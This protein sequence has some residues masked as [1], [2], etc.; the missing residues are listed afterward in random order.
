[1]KR[2]L[3][4]AALAMALTPG[5]L[6]GHAAAADPAAVEITFEVDD[7]TGAVMVALFD[8]EA[9]YQK[10]LP[11]KAAR[12]PIGSG[13]VKATFAGLKPGRYAAK[14]FH[15]VD[16]DGGMNVNAF[17]MPTEQYGFSNKAQPRFGPAPWSAAA[18]EVGAGSTAQTIA[19]KRSDR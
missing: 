11:V 9:G 10:N 4:A 1:M 8:S 6:P 14:A 7:R 3:T 17:D 18:F 2:L 13:A 15:D 12:V 19:L 16:D 5:V